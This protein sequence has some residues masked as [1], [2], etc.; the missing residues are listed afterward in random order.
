MT[1]ERVAGAHPDSVAEEVLERLARAGRFRDEETAEHVER[2][3]RTCALVA[4]ELGW[5]PD[6]CRALRA[7]SAMHD[8]GKVGIPDTV[9]RKPGRLT[10]TEREIVEGHPRIGHDILMGSGD[11]VLQLAATVALTHH[12]RVDGTGYPDRLEGDAI[13]LAGRI[14]AVA[15]VFDALTHD[16]VYRT[17]LTIP[18]AV[19][20]IREGAG[21]QFDAA[22]VAAFERVLAEIEALQSLYPDSTGDAT[23]GSLFA[24]PCDAL[25]VLVVEDHEAVARGLGLLLRR[26]G[27]EIAGSA[28]TSAEATSLLE[29][30]AIDL[31]LVDLD[32]AGEN[33]LDL[34]PVAKRFGVRVLLYTGWTDRQL[35]ATARAAGVDGISSKTATP[36]ELAEAIRAVA[37]GDSHFDERVTESAGGGFLRHAARARGSV[38]RLTVREREIVGLISQGLTAKAVADALFLSPETVRTHIKNARERKGAKTTVHLVSLAAADDEI[39]IG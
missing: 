28:R 35:I 26:E 37:R 6:E 36:S 3:S 17:A 32:L 19:A 16:R 5:S 7:A 12:E 4:R 39:R 2:V 11:E 14:A 30:R 8:I 31:A 23:N 18:D 15:D 10:P 29:R 9:L 20:A 24:A 34:A 22:V 33:G 13:P 21:K 1:A 25:R 38:R 27:F